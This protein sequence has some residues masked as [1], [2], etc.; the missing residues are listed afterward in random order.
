MVDEERE[1]AM[2]RVFV[3]HDPDHHLV[4]HEG[5]G[6][7]FVLQLFDGGDFEENAA[8]LAVRPGAGITR[9]TWSPPVPMREEL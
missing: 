5:E 3:G 7:D 8:E 9:L 2:A 1:R 6:I 4:G